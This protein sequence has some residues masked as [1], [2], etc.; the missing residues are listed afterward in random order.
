MIELRTTNK[1]TEWIALS[2][3]LPCDND[4]ND[5]TIIYSVERCEDGDC[6]STN[7]TTTWHNAT[8][9]DPCTKYEFIVKIL[10]FWKSDGVSLTETTSDTSKCTIDLCLTLYKN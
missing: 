8:G 4:I 9:L 5:T 1:S 6:N 2:W 7:V 10:T 3:E